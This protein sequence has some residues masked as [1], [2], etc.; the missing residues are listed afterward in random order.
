M[1]MRKILVIDNYDSFTYNLVHILRELGEEPVVVRNDK[2]TVDDVDNFDL[3]LLS[4]GPGLPAQ[5]GIMPEVLKKFSATKSILGICLG[6]QAIGECFGGKL[7][8]LP[9]VYHG[10]VTPVKLTR[11]DTLF[12]NIPTEF[13]VCRYHS[14]V[15]NHE[16]FPEELEITSVDDN[17]IIMSVK[18]KRY[19]V[20]GIQYHPESV[21][22]EHG[23]QIIK[24]WLE[25]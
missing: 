12:Q 7:Y 19:N 16:G 25:S 2:I 20:R 15:I 21:M 3:I 10:M 23:K 5:A 4:P 14:W 22:T 17:G 6:H 9:Q 24:N 1:M 13:K 11:E 8:N 18:H